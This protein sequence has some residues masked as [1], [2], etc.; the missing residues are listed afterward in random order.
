[1]SDDQSGCIRAFFNRRQ[2]VCAVA[3]FCL[4]DCPVRRHSQIS[5]KSF[6]VQ[7]RAV[8]LCLTASSLS[9]LA[10]FGAIIASRTTAEQFSG[11]SFPGV[12][13]AAHRLPRA[14]T[15]ETVSR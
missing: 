2:R 13:Q 15:R 11:R 8:G 7:S 9:I 5:N 6:G 10:P 1:D 3:M 14:L 4:R 12:L